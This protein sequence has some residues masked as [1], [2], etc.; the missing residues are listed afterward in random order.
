MPALNIDDLNNG[1]K[2]LDHIAEV[3]TSEKLTATDRL[4]RI[5]STL[6]GAIYSLKAFNPKGEFVAGAAYA[7]KDVY[8]SQGIAY[9]ALQN[10]VA[11]TVAADLAAGK[12]SVH[13]GATREDL[14]AT[15]GSLLI[16]FVQTGAGA[17]LRTVRDKLLPVIDVEDY[18]AAPDG[19]DC[20]A[21]FKKAAAALRA[22]KG[23]RLRFTPGADYNCLPTGGAYLDSIFDLTGCYGVT[24][25]MNGA[26]IITGPVTLTQYMF[27]LTGTWGVK[28]ENMRLKS[29]YEVLKSDAGIFW[30]RARQG[31]RSIVFENVECEYGCVGFVAQ[32]KIVGE[33]E[34]NNRVRGI[35][36][37]N[38]STFGT[39]YPANFQ[40]AGDNVKGNIRARNSGR[41]YFLY[42]VHDHK[43]EIDSQ[44]GGPFSDILIKCYGSTDFSSKTENIRIIYRSEGRYPGA[45]NQ[46][47]DEAMVA[48]DFQQHTVNPGPCTFANIDVQFDVSPSPADRNQNLFYVRKYDSSGNADKVTGRGHSLVGLKLHGVGLSLQNLLAVSLNL[49]GRAG[50][51]WTGE[52]VY[53]LHIHDMVLSNVAAQDAI[54]LNCAP[55]VGA[56]KIE[57]VRSPGGIAL[58]NIGGKELSIQES[59]FRNY[60]AFSRIT[61]SY[62][63]V[64]TANG[65]VPNIGAG[66]LGGTYTV[67]G[68]LCTC[69][70]YMKA[71]AD[72]NFAS[73]I[74]HFSIPL[75][76]AVGSQP[77]V[78][79]A[80]ALDSGA[81]YLNGT[82][83]ID[84]GA[85]TMEL[86]LGATPGNFANALS[87]II[88]AN[89]DYVS[90]TITYPIE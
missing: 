10:H 41:S 81:N 1:K 27:D 6:L 49:F 7:M 44:Q 57:R 15:L 86:L 19:R 23:G 64:W 78:G 68:K 20:T 42:N 52:S 40:G 59:A 24:V 66:Q 43:V 2:D 60:S 33:G 32:G 55:I 31:A 51:D 63:V 54:V 12:V 22:Q 83:K 26:R 18:G 3:A 56:S 30:F 69:S 85:S 67:Q 34:D 16:G 13:Q 80:Y 71:A 17:V 79:C 29:G 21:A 25:E 8:T 38:F 61:Q 88:W 82:C 39:Y 72:T 4:G 65:G 5:K 58:S 62:T 50:E 73:G 76:H 70:V 45:G 28:F 77:T 46:N 14:G 89:Q 47:F 9:V 75:K 37:K 11:T 84:A 87:P 90:A 35:V 36:F 48:M 74:W 53:G